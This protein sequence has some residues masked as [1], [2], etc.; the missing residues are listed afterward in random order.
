MSNFI[1]GW[2]T[3]FVIAITLAVIL[4]GKWEHKWKIYKVKRDLRDAARDVRP[5]DQPVEIQKPRSAL[6]GLLSQHGMAV[7]ATPEWWVVTAMR[8]GAD[9]PHAQVIQHAA[10][11]RAGVKG[12]DA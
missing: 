1:Y 10:A 9:Y 2:L 11:T 3:G 8:L 5:P 4:V 7:I 6:T 12:F